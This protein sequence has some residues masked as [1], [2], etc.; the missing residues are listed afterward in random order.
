L[1]NVFIDQREA[2]FTQHA[3]HFAQNNRN[4]LGVMQNVAESHRTKRFIRCRKTGTIVLPIIDC[5]LSAASQIN[6]DNASA[7]HRAQMMRDEAVATADVEHFGAARYHTRY[8]QSHV[9]SAADFASAP[10]AH[11]TTLQGTNNTLK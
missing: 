4:I 10:L 7:E 2:A 11:P 8:F 5:R 6:P 1:G 9:I 3:A